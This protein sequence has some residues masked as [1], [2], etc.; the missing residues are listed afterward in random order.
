[1][2]KCLML[3]G[4]LGSLALA[5]GCVLHTGGGSTAPTAAELQ[6]VPPGQ[7]PALIVRNA[8]N[9]TICYVQFSST[10]QSTWGPDR[11]GA[12]E[13]VPPGQ[14]RGWRVPPDMYDV[15]VSDCQR[16]VLADDRSVAVAG[17]GLVVTY[18]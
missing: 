2:R 1:M 13:T 12:T 18:H 17:D 15:R 6:A 4:W 14:L 11:L 7:N 8:S 16:N 3:A 5:S 10:A 9:R